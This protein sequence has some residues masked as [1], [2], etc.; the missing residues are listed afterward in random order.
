MVKIKKSF[1]LI[2]IASFIFAL[3]S[4]GNLPYSILYCFLL[5][6]LVAIVNSLVIKK[7]LNIHLKI[8][9]NFMYTNDESEIELRVYNDSIFP[10][11]YLEIQSDIFNKSIQKYRG[12][13]ISVGI[14][15]NKFIK[16][17][18]KFPVRG[19]YHQG[20]SN[21]NFGDLFG[22]VKWTKTFKHKGIIK[23]YPY[24]YKINKVKINGSRIKK[25]N[26]INKSLYNNLSE[27]NET[28][29]NIRE[30]RI[31]DNYR[32]INWKVSA[33]HGKIFIKEYENSESPRI[34]LFLDFRNEPLSFDS[35]GEA[36]EELVDFF[37]S[38]ISHLIGTNLKLTATLICS[39]KTNFN[40]AHEWDMEVINEYIINHYSCG[41]G[42]IEKYMEKEIGEVDKNSSVI[43]VTCD[44]SKTNLDYFAGL[45]A[46]G[47]NVTLFYLNKG[48]GV[49]KETINTAVNNGVICYNIEEIR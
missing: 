18:V 2:I 35:T 42:I 9:K 8:E 24:I 4:G 29:K 27:N 44:L 37:L 33:K 14:N 10:I 22:I 17:R 23:V 47:Y 19:L 46:K 41:G 30:Y 39:E 12:D 15:S 21:C 7:Y 28:V 45:A 1:I 5:L 16:R 25:S 32:R 31:G 43:V 11:S 48:I 6:F 49:K 40:F 36:E 20:T 38:L 34:K 3:M 26:A 13:I